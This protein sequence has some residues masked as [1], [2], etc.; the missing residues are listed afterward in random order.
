MCNDSDDILFSFAVLI[1]ATHEPGTGCIDWRN[2]Q[3]LAWIRP[4]TWMST[5]QAPV[6]TRLVYRNFKMG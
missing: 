4:M 6:K 5:T 3:T 1:L 2:E